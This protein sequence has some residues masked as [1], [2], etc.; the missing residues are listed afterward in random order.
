LNPLAI[1]I[2]EKYIL[3]K[4]D[5]RKIHTNP[6]PRS[7]GIAVFL[8][9][10]ILSFFNKDVRS[11]IIPLSIIFTVGILDDI[12]CL[13][14]KLKLF[15]QILVAIITYYLG[16]EI[17]SV[18]IGNFT[19][20]FTYI[21]PFITALWIV[22]IMNAINLID[23]LD[24]LAT[25]MVLVSTLAFAFLTYNSPLTLVSILLGICLAFLRVNKFPAKIFLGDS[26][27]LLFGYLLSIISISV[28]Q[29]NGYSQAIAIFL[30][31]FVPIIDTAWA[32]LRRLITNKPVFSPDKNH[33]HHKVLKADIKDDKALIIIS[34]L[35]VLAAFL[36]VLI[37]YNFSLSTILL[38]FILI[39]MTFIIYNLDKYL[40]L[41]LI[42]F[43]TEKEVAFSKE[44]KTTNT[45]L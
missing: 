44:Q 31:I 2:G 5:Y 45:H 4:P 13:S 34:L 24:G 28:I 35:S 11:I 15:F 39:P 21:T 9:L 36:G 41:F 33:L 18:A 37:Y 8:T 19:L 7:G 23:G 14:A 10:F 1:K 3:D 12:Y 6:K 16:Y 20:Q 38:S 42:V 40:T 26:G 25:S 27:S 32:F 29:V 17:N 30:I 43:N 22:G